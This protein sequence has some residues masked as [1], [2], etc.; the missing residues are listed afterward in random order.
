MRKIIVSITTTQNSDWRAKIREINKLGLKEAGLF[1]TCLEKKERQEMYKML[2]SSTLKKIPLVHI[3]H[4]MPPQELDYLVK[5]F[6]VEAF[7]TH[8][9]SEFPFLYQH[10]K[11]RK[12]IFI[13][14]VYSGIDEKEIRRFG[15][16]C[17]DTAHLEN[18]R[19]LE[20][21]K[22]ER[23]T[24]L[25]EKYRIGCNHIS[26]FKKYSRRDEEGYLRY[27]F[28]WLGALS[29]LDYL[30]NYPKKYFSQILAIELSNT[31]GKQLKARD[32]LIKKIGL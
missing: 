9:D 3:R 20:P 31:I 28:H 15:G 6:K 26:C 30:N 10:P 13:E 17:L 8:S 25:L 11:Y 14:N 1:P 4:D 29:Q 32:Y 19:M 7:N 16:I 5:R 12:I 22:F 21:E 24:V 18:D 2:E 27:D 23:N